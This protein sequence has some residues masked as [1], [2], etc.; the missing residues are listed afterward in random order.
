MITYTRL[1]FNGRFGNQLFQFA[2]T[3]GIAEK[4]GY[5]VKFPLANLVHGKHQQ[6][7]DG[8]KFVARIDFTN[9]FDIDENYFSNEIQITGRANERFFH[10][11][12]GMMNVP[13]GTDVSGYF[14]SDKYFSHCQNKIRE[15]LK[16][17][18]GIYV[19]ALS[20]KPETD[21]KLVAVHVRRSDYL[22]LPDHHP[23]VGENYLEK[24]IEMFNTDEHHFVVCSDDYTWCNEKWGDDENFSVI[25]SHSHFVDFALMSMC[26]HHIISNSSFSWWSSFLSPNKDKKVIAPSIWFG[27]KFKNNNTK[28]LYRSEMIKI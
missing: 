25:K 20:F 24:A 4:N 7:T 5:D 15:V 19:L 1:G 9:C 23:W 14:Q 8:K 3:I 17:K 13:D 22:T 18:D 6:L 2:G 12:E 21:K 11:D 26:D 10:F 28:D 16:F 27:P